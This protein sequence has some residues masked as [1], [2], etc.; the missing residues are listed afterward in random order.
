MMATM[1]SKE[2]RIKKERDKLTK[3]FSAIDERRKR[4]VEKTIDNCAY[5]SVILE[6]LKAQMDAKG[7]EAYVSVYQNGENQWGTKKSPEIEIYNQVF[8]NYLKGVKQLTDL[9]PEEMRINSEDKEINA[10]N[11]FLKT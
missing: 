10:I 9:L 5:M 8:S 1:I 3:Q 6:D 4:I 7:D 11:E 2:E